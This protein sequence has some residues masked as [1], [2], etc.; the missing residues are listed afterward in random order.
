VSPKDGDLRIK[1]G[2]AMFKLGQLEKAR[3]E[4]AKAAATGHPQ[5]IRRLQIVDAKLGK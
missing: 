4:F 2:D 1:L 3:T 5:A